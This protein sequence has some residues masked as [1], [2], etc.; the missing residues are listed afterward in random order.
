MS[1]REDELSKLIEYHNKKYWIDDDPEI[2]DD[3]YD[4]LVEE[5][6]SINPNNNIFEKI[7]AVFTN[8][9]RVKLSEPMLSLDKVYDFPSLLDWAE[10]VARNNNE[11]FI[12]EPKYDG[13]SIMYQD[14]MLVT[15][16][17]GY[18]GENFTDKIKLIN[19]ET[20]NYTGPLENY[21]YNKRGEVILKKSTFVNNFNKIKRKDG[22]HYK[23]PRN[24]LSGFLKPKETNISLGPL[25]VMIDYELYS[26]ELSLT[27]LR[28]FDLQNL[29]EQVKE[30][31]YPT[32]G[33]VIKLKDLEYGETLGMTAHH[34]KWQ[35]AYKFANPKGESVLNSVTWFLGK[36]NTVNPVGNIKPV[37]I[38]GHEIKN[39]NLH[40]A[41]FI[42]MRDI[43]IGD[44]LLIERCG[45]I[46][47]QVSKV[48]PGEHRVKIIINKCPECGSDLEYIEPNLLC[49]NKNCTGSLSKKLTDSCW[50]LGIENI[51]LSTVTKLVE[52]LN[53]KSIVDIL[54]L[55]KS[56]IL[57]LPGFAETSSNN[58][59]N[60]I[61]KVINKP[62]EDWRV[63]SCLNIKGIGEEISKLILTEIPIDKL[64]T[65][66]YEKYLEIPQMGNER[67]I[68]LFDG[69]IYN[70]TIFLELC[71]MLQI[72]KINNIKNNN[73][74]V[75]FTGKF[76]K[77][78]NYYVKLAEKHN[79]NVYDTVKKDL[80]YLVCSDFSST[81]SKMEKAKKN[82][83]TIIL[84]DDFLKM[85]KS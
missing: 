71:S 75:C 20:F 72:K 81:K 67:V 77:P 80:T 10:K 27:E 5:L 3:E 48:I 23:T 84:I 6:K 64:L 79:F 59:Y 85:I 18:I 78:R 66:E 38:S 46:I 55:T 25:L 76:S 22:K 32:D 44:T 35:I 68:E 61:Q 69:F 1:N 52:H 19:L 82:N 41:K 83:V 74:S 63:L 9:R 50:R 30:W 33:L 15:R 49:T 57:S 12:I 53:V 29:I 62:I 36:G 8:R 43:H 42:L 26:T 14:N 21:P 17:N 13:W 65:T 7:T 47:P 31:D 54:K 70:T 39:V 73:N 45:D 51:G 58:L 37:T 11:I 4:L 24:A 56:Q 2:E 40:N 28:K 34:P 60:E 16:G